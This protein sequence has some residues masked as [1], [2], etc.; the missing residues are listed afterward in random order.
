[1]SPWARVNGTFLV[2]REDSGRYPSSYDP[3]FGIMLA[4]EIKPWL[5]RQAHR[6]KQGTAVSS[7]AVITMMLTNNGDHCWT[8]QA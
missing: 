6:G 3:R 1:M 8:V 4:W 5:G 2:A 7:P